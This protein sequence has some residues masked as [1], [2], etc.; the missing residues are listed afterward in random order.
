MYSA[1]VLTASI[2]MSLPHFKAGIF[3]LT[4]AISEMFSFNDQMFTTLPPHFI[5]FFVFVITSCA[6]EALI[7]PSYINT[8]VPCNTDAYFSLSIFFS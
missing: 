4:N 1:N 5:T 6:S 3:R 8:I 7:T 2:P